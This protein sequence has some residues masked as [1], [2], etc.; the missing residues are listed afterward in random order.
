[1]REWTRRGGGQRVVSWVG[2]GTLEILLNRRFKLLE[3]A[4]LDIELPFEVRAHFPL[5]YAMKYAREGEGVEDDDGGGWLRQW[6][7]LLT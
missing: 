7:R 5:Q 1:M 4:G 2:S 3:C 6:K